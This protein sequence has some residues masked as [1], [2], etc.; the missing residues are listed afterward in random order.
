MEGHKLLIKDLINGILSKE[1]TRSDVEDRINFAKINPLYKK[2]LMKL[3]IKED[4]CVDPR[5]L[6]W[7]LL[8]LENPDSFN[9]VALFEK[10]SFKQYKEDL[11]GHGIF[12]EEDGE[13]IIESYESI[14][15]PVRGTRGSA[16]YDFVSPV[17]IVLKPGEQIVV[18][19][20]IRC[21]MKENWVLKAYPRSS[22]GTKYRVQFN[23]TVPI[24]DSDYYYSKNEGHIMF[25]ILNDGREGKVFKLSKGE[26]LCQGVFVEYGITFDDEVST[27]RTGGFGSTGK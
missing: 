25:K 22:S 23:N 17:D 6:L 26:K 3:L 20:G 10:V 24:L 27:E 12:S 4:E 13:L 8:D 15:L 16:G 11:I 19:T 5:E 14:S 21:L 18:C 7:K 1:L 2:G 9:R